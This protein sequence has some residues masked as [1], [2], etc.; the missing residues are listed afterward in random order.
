MAVFK[1][2]DPTF[3]PDENGFVGVDG[4]YAVKGATKAYDPVVGE[5]ED[6]AEEAETHT[7]PEEPEAPKAPATPKKK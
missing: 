3:E 1:A 2:E 6:E 5:G 7:Q 4:D